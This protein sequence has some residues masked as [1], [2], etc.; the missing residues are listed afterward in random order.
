MAT[1]MVDLSSLQ[2]VNFGGGQTG[3]SDGTTIFDSGGNALSASELAQYGAFTVGAPGTIP[4]PPP[5]GG[6]SPPL[7]SASGSGGAL[8]GLSGMFSG[9]GA[10]IAGAYNSA[11][12]PTIQ[13]PTQ[14]TLVFN[15]ST[16]GY[17][18]ATAM[19]ASSTLMPLL[20]LAVAGVAIFLVMR[21]ERRG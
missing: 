13:T 19:N 11:A 9:I 18:T 1:D 2:T 6:A 4:G 16:G 15:P 8:S 17:T 3:Y 20:L 5:S 12:R 10:A 7:V 14:G 21:E